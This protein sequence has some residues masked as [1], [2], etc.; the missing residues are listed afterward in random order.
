MKRDLLNRIGIFGCWMAGTLLAFTTILPAAT[1]ADDSDDIV[2]DIS[3]AKV[4][5]NLSATCDTTTS[6]LDKRGQ[7][8][9]DSATG[10]LKYDVSAAN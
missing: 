10:S 7:L 8:V 2:L 5:E 4:G 3:K 9:Y 1:T 6:N